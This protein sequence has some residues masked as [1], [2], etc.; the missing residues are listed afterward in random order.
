MGIPPVRK[1]W[2]LDLLRL[3]G[4]SRR[5]DIDYMMVQMV[6]DLGARHGELQAMQI[7]NLSMLHSELTN[8]ARELGY[9]TTL[10]AIEALLGSYSDDEDRWEQDEEIQCLCHAWLTSYHALQNGTP[11]W[12]CK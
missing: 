7:G 4:L 5:F 1:P 9:E 8:L 3:V 11:M 10:E 12:L 6:G 2:Y